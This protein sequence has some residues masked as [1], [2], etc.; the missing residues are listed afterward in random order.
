MYKRKGKA[1]RNIHMYR[2]KQLEN[3]LWWGSTYQPPVSEAHTPCRNIWRAW[4]PI[5]AFRINKSCSVSLKDV[6]Q[7]N[8]AAAWATVTR[9]YDGTSSGDSMVTKTV[10]S[11]STVLRR[12]WMQV[13]VGAESP[14]IFSWQHLHPSCTDV[15]ELYPNPFW[16]NKSVTFWHIGIP[17]NVWRNIYLQDKNQS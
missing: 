13:S 15:D 1:R 7:R 2:W 4:E 14:R 11:R 6:A 12:V 17:L 8:W 5:S 3:V 9:V 10:S 16:V